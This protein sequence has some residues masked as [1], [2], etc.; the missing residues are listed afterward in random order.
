MARED[1]QRRLDAL[2]DEVAEMAD[3]VC[4]R[5]RLALDALVEDDPA[6]ARAVIDGDG[7]V[8]ERYL[9]LERQCIDL[10]ALQQ[11]VAGDLRF[12][13]ASFKIITDLERIGDLAT[14]L[15]GYALDADR[16]LLP[17]VN[18][19]DIGDLAVSMVEDAVA[20]YARRDDGWL[21]HEVADRDNELDALCSHASTVVVRALI[22]H[23]ATDG[24]GRD[25]AEA[26][27][28]DVS[29]LLLTVRDLERVGDHAVNIAAR[30]LYM[31][32]NSDEL[33]Y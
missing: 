2:D 32:T 14:N 20:A 33:I 17:E 24:G 31:T 6:G 21:C 26:L 4:D 23:E 16:E 11:P 25:E 30:T 3:L 19:A 28:H 9:D 22:D 7:V 27:M 15:A 5:L 18:L 10:V 1:L 13:A 12:V 29:V 8:N